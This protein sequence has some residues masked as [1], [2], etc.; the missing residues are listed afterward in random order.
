M[1]GEM[2]F[3]CPIKKEKETIGISEILPSFLS[4]HLRFFILLLVSIFHGWMIHSFIFL[5]TSSLTLIFFSYSK[6]LV[7]GIC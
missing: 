6:A 4:F 2:P 1:L 7:Q 5:Q 3:P